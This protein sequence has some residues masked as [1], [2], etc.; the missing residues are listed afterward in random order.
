MRV[1]YYIDQDGHKLGAK[2]VHNDWEPVNQIYGER[3]A[4]HLVETVG[5]VLL[6][7]T[8]RHLKVRLNFDSLGDTAL[9]RLLYELA[10]QDQTNQRAI[11]IVDGGKTAF[12]FAGGVQ[13]I[14]FVVAG[15]REQA[16]R[17]RPQFGRRHVSMSGEFRAAFRR[18]TELCA[19][20]R[21][22]DLARVRQFLR[23]AFRGRYVLAQPDVEAGRLRL[24]EAGNGYERLGTNV[25]RYVEG[26]PFSEFGEQRYC[27]FV[28]QA[29][30]EAWE[31]RRPVLEEIQAT[32]PNGRMPVDLQIYERI[33]L[34]IPTTEGEALLSATLIKN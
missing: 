10:D 16:R 33:L 14:D 2:S 4:W 17:R 9:A 29:Y 1:R 21:A 28:K 22:V 13:A 3:L 24:L 26:E 34:P 32:T 31:I 20:D 11:F 8:E 7:S 6:E 18:L 12:R 5:Y 19:A 27:E 30:R 15:L 23:R 25:R